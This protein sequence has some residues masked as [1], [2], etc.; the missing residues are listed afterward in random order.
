[1]KYMSLTHKL[2]WVLL[3][4]NHGGETGIPSVG[5]ESVDIWKNTGGEG[6]FLAND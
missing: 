1:M 2:H 5:V 4:L 6:G 3:D